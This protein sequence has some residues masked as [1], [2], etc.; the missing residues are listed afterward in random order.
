M[1]LIAKKSII[2]KKKIQRK[3]EYRFK[4]KVPQFRSGDFSY[5]SYLYH[6]KTLPYN[7]SYRSFSNYCSKAS[8]FPGKSKDNFLK[9]LE[10]RL[11]SILYRAQFCRS[12]KQAQQ[13]INHRQILVNGEAATFV[14]YIVKPGDII[15]LKTNDQQFK[16][17]K[18][19]FPKHSLIKKTKNLKKTFKLTARQKQERK[20]RLKLSFKRRRNKKKKYFPKFL[21][22]P[23][24]LEINPWLKTAIFLYSP[25]KLF[26]QTE[27]KV[28]LIRRSLKRTV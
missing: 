25:Q 3:K 21:F 23:L 18:L 14:G 4:H 10:L 5:V 26:F 20:K 2:A 17:G 1:K 12:F 8:F 15:A 6:R 9:Y 28:D 22:K 7:L 19:I 27:L 16:N 24:H 11:D 13:M